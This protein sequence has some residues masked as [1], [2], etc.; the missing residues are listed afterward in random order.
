MKLYKLTD[1]KG[2]TKNNT[3]WDVGVTHKVPNCKVPMLCSDNVL[4]AYTNINLAFLLNP[5]H[6]D[7]NNPLIWECE[8]DVAVKDWGKVGV[9]ALT[10]TKELIVPKWVKSDNERLVIIAFA[11][12]C[13]EAVL[14]IYEDE[15]PNNDCPRKAIEAA[16]EYLKNPSARAA[17][18]AA[19]AAAYAAAYAADAAADA[20]D[21]A[22]DAA[23]AADA[24]RAARAAA[25]AA[26]AAAHA[27][28]R[29]ADEID[30]AFLADQAVKMIFEK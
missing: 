28:A 25:Y 5:V 30:F 6:G 9:F 3:H 11:I 16:K 27:A 20:A 17:A 15:Y 19:D 26:H 13:A 7:I 29:A 21:A 23:D 8:G 14:K 12:L 22:A 2:N 24:A 1:Q 4:H 18:Y 10:I